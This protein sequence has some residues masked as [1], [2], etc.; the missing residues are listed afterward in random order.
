VMV[1]GTSGTGRRSLVV[2]H[3]RWHNVW[4]PISESGRNVIPA[5][6]LFLILRLGIQ[7]S[8]FL[9]RLAKLFMMPLSGII[10]IGARALLL[11]LVMHTCPSSHS[12]VNIVLIV[13]NY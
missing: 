8:N 1:D 10:L 7:H 4:K 3:D 12:R 2:C 11:M 5:H 6:Q 13:C 9:I